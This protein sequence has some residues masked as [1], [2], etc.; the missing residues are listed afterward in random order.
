MNLTNRVQLIGNV[1]SEPL[2]RVFNQG[3]KSARFSVRTIDVYKVNEKYIKETQ[4]HT[5]VAWGQIAEI[6]EKNI[7]LGAEIVIDGRLTRRSYNDKNGI[8]QYIS[9][10]V[11]NTIIC[12]AENVPHQ[13]NSD[14]RKS[15]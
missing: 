7:S 1:T 6:A 13:S 3:N 2:V 9:E 10:V 11:A 5:V 12:K 14:L 4:Y 8:L 15:A